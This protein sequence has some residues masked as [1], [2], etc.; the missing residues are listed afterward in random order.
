[1][2]FKEKSDMHVARKIWH[3]SSG[4]LVLL[5]YHQVPLKQS[6]WAKIALT[7]GLLSTLFDIARLKIPFFRKKAAKF[8]A[9]IL[10]GEEYN[11]FTGVPFYAFGCFITL[12]FNSEPWVVTS[13]YFLVF[14]DP[15]AS[16]FG[17]KYGKKKLLGDKTWAG[18][19]AGSITG[20]LVC[21]FTTQFIFNLPFNFVFILL[22]GIGVGLIEALSFKIE[23]NFSIPACSGFLLSMLASFMGVS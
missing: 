5:I 14:V 7:V 6:E 10:R 16:Y 2:I 15:L 12:F 3:L 8:L 11:S 17:I 19:I 21:Y 18:F 9:P 1:M 22:S 23:D 4:V 13:I 20:I